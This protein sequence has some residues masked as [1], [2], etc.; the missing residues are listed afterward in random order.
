MKMNIKCAA[1]L[2]RVSPRTVSRAILNEPNG[3]LDPYELTSSQTLG[4][5]Y[6]C[7]PEVFDLAYHGKPAHV[8]LTPKEAIEY[9]KIP[10]RTF[11]HKQRQGKIK[12]VLRFNKVV[13][14]TREYLDTVEL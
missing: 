7:R 9:L 13:R 2:L 3:H 4:F 11:R 8:L 6:D 12:P 5:V 14:F 10:E 1:R